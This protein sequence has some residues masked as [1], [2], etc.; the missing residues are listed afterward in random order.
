MTKDQKIELLERVPPMKAV[1]RMALPTVLSQV[2]TLLY[3]LA[4]TFFVGQ[5]NDPMQLAALSLSF[6]I[7]MVIILLGNLFGIGANSVIA[8]ALGRRDYD[9]VKKYP[10]LPFTAPLSARRSSQ[11]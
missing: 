8:R 2:V 3:N 4:D 1:A 10:P 7:F 9:Y 11:S 6:P 5:L